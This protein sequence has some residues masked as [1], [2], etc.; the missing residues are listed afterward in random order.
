[1]PTAR[2]SPDIVRALARQAVRGLSRLRRRVGRGQSLARAAQSGDIWMPS[3]H[4]EYSDFVAQ[5]YEALEESSGGGGA[6]AENV[7]EDPRVDVVH[8]RQ[9]GEKNIDGGYPS[10]SARAAAEQWDQRHADALFD[11]A[12]FDELF[13]DVEEEE[14]DDDDDDDDDDTDDDGDE[15][16]EDKTKAKVT[17]E[18][19]DT[20]RVLPPHRYC[21]SVKYCTVSS[22]V[23]SR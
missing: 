4:L 6:R 18:L 20:S 23:R 8:L 22:F 19:G 17:V 1:M 2:P 13:D 12:Q 5:H 15:I 7:G 3:E 10:A 14:V 11:E 16:A 9:Y 21:I